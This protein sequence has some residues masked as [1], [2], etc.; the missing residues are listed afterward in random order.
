MDR[1]SLYERQITFSG[2]KLLYFGGSHSGL[3][4]RTSKA[5]L[6]LTETAPHAAH[7]RVRGTVILGPVSQ[8][9]DD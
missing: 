7:L 2:H 3:R 4:R 8:Y 5:V 6:L 9:C 1:L